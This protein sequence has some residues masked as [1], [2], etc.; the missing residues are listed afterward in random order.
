MLDNKYNG[1]NAYLI[2]KGGF[3]VKCISGYKTV[4]LMKSYIKVL[5]RESERRLDN[6]PHLMLTDSQ[7]KNFTRKILYVYLLLNYALSKV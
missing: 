4:A 6:K 5:R 3:F 7:G 2:G 1:M